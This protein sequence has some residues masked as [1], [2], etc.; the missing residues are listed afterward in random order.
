MRKILAAGLLIVVAGCIPQTH[1]KPNTY[2]EVGEYAYR[3]TIGATAV[4]GEFSIES[5]TV[6]LEAADHSCRRLDL[7]LR[8]EPLS[9]AFSCGGGPAFFR[10]VV[11]SKQP[12]LSE[13]SSTESVKKSV[14]VCTRWIV[15]KERQQICAAS[16]KEIVT[17]NVPIR[18]RLHVTRLAAV[19]KR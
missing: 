6:L 9:H 13:W 8:Q 10:V 19:D 3:M 2:R 15:T 11:N 17:E 5:D 7:G 16:R 18:G 4:E 12:T 1:A 14:Q